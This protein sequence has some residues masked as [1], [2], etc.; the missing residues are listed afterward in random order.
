M[1]ERQ[2]DSEFDTASGLTETPPPKDW[3]DVS[4]YL[5]EESDRSFEET[6]LRHEQLVNPN[7]LNL[8]D[9]LE[10]SID[11]TGRLMVLSNQFGAYRDEGM[12]LQDIRRLFLVPCLA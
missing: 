9:M 2:I 8:R 11:D 6:Q 7:G 4:R 5:A 3:G 10:G 1:S 12:S